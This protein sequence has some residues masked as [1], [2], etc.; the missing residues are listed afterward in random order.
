MVDADP[1]TE[2]QRYC[3]YFTALLQSLLRLAVVQN[4]AEL[5]NQRS[6]PGHEDYYLL[7]LHNHPWLWCLYQVIVLYTVYTDVPAI[8]KVL[9]G[10]VPLH[11]AL[12]IRLLL[13]MY[14]NSVTADVNRS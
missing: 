7:A 9:A 1:V 13:Y 5:G 6:S 11:G 3:R 8:S 2:V 4:C 14:C 10:I 12:D